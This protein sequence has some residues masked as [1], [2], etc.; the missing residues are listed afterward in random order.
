MQV[1]QNKDIALELPLLRRL[2]TEHAQNSMA[3]IFANLFNALI[4]SYFFWLDGNKNIVLAGAAIFILIV[5]RRYMLAKQIKSGDVA[6]DDLVK[7]KRSIE[8]NA[9]AL[10][11][12]WGA[13]ISVLMINAGP[14][15]AILLVIVGA[16]KMAT[17]AISYRAISR[18]AYY[19]I[20]SSG[21]GCGVALAIFGSSSTMA[22]A[23]L[24][25]IFML[26]LMHNV[27]GNYQNILEEYRKS[28]DIKNN[29]E[30]INMLLHDFKEQGSDWLIEIDNDG[31]VVDPSARFAHAMNMTIA[32][33]SGANFLN[34]FKSGGDKLRV[35]DNI[36]S[37][38]AF[39]NRYLMFD[40][41]ANEH[42]LAVS[43]RPVRDANIAFRGVASDI[44]T[45]RAAEMKVSYMA[46]FD[47][48]TG[49]ANRFQFNQRLNALLNSEQN[50]LALILIDLD[51]FKSVNDSLG[52]SA[53]DKLLKG[54]ARSLQNC[55]TADQFVARLGGD[56]FA[57]IIPDGGKQDVQNVA[58][59]ILAAFKQPILCD[60]QSIVIGASIGAALC[61][62][63][64]ENSDEIMINADLALYSA[65]ANGRNQLKFYQ[66]D[67]SD[68]AKNRQIL[69]QDLHNALANNELELHYQSF[70]DMKLGKVVGY[71]ALLRWQHPT[72][73]IIMPNDF[74]SIAEETG[75]I[76]P[77]GEWIIRQAME[78]MSHWDE[79]IQMAINLSPI[80]LR[81]SN[82]IPTIINALATNAVNPA[83]IS[84]EITENVLMQESEANLEILHKIR[85][86]GLKIA[87]DD[88]GTGYSSLNYL[89]TFPFDKIKIDRCFV[90][91]INE[92]EDCRAIVQS[93]VNLANQLGMTTTAE[94]VEND[95]QAER[96]LAHGCDHAQGF[97]YGRA[98]PLR[99][100]ALRPIISENILETAL[101]SY[102]KLPVT[103]GAHT[104]RS[105]KKYRA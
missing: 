4:I 7:I 18:A 35:A 48:L 95:L 57:I 21:I 89:R 77:I 60:E 9:L 86:L 92:R 79:D 33:L 67:M 51:Q 94:G 96:L 61:P 65:K 47:S 41:G 23:F 27:R 36:K 58:D 54:V 59:K 72:R 75:L 2:L 87:L 74:I 100:T 55:L 25:A 56:E 24:L 52:H 91:E 11:G 53:G 71:E 73:G 16:G 30:T 43:A 29:N 70:L 45:Q 49:L 82:L 40:N 13:T 15:Q 105:H 93:V 12:W 6:D 103:K 62:D 5:S 46:H 8:V 97:L 39:R 76:V 84:M 81:S 68:I 85:E 31:N 26:I 104:R 42:C 10:G 63:N 17:G 19:F 32:E 34:L 83:R 80:Q 101:N 22:G 20:A 28:Q 98:V 78:D 69:E 14:G 3:S 88:F 38:L 102:K 66:A 1:E 44:T 64:G 50:K 37:N 90:D 99:D